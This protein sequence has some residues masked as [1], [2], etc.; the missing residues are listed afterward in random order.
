MVHPVIFQLK[1]IPLNETSGIIEWVDNLD[2]LRSIIGRLMKERPDAK[3]MKPR[4]YT[5][6]ETNLE[7]R[8]G[9]QVRMSHWS[10]D[11]C[12]ISSTSTA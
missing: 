2:S 4:E 6:F 8:A 5:A 10:S 12:R 3:P 9:N 7:D 1:V 11:H